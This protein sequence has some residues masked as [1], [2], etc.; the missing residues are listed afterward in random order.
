MMTYENVILV[1]YHRISDYIGID[2]RL[3]YIHIRK[4]QTFEKEGE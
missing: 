3:V 1:Y 2:H 4:L